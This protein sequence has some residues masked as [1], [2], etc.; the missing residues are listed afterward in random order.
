M[1]NR[2]EKLRGELTA[3]AADLSGYAE[4]DLAPTQTFLELGFDSLFLT[5]LAVQYQ[6]AF[7]QKITFRQLINDVPTIEALAGYLDGVMPADAP[8]AETP[9]E[10]V[11]APAPDTTPAP[12]APA[13]TSAPVAV[14]SVVPV[15]VSAPRAIAPVSEG[16]QGILA[17]QLALMTKQLEML[18]AARGAQSTAASAPVAPAETVVSTAPSSSPPAAESGAAPKDAAP[19]TPS[20]PAGFGPNVSDDDGPVLDAR[21]KAHVARLVARYNARTAG[22]KAAT[23]RDRGVHAD[24]RTAAGFNSLWKEMVYPIVVKKSHG[25]HLWDIDDNQYI[26]LLN[27][28]GP[29]FFGH[30]APFVVEALREQLEDGYEIGPQ[31]PRAGD[32][33]RLMCELTGMDRVSWVNTGSEAVQAAIRIARTVTGRDKIVVFKG[34]YHGNFDEV[35]VRG[36]GPADAPRTMPLAPGIPFKS[37]ENVIALDYGE[38]SAI[39]YIKANADDIAA[40]LVEPVQSRRPEFQPREFLHEL[41]ALTKDEEIVLVF[42]EV[43]T[44]FRIRPGGAQEYFGIE[45]DMATYGKIIGGG[46]PIGVVAGR[47][48]F[49]D[50]FDGGQWSY[51]DASKPMAGVTF[52]AGTFVRH[53]LAI[54]AA[55]ASLQYLISAGPG[56]QEGVNRMT[57]RLATAL[58]DFFKERG[59]KIHVA[60]FASQMFF[61]NEEDSELATLFFYHLRA[62]GVHILEN[63]PSYVTAAHTEEDI[64]AVIDAAKDAVLEMQADGILPPAPTG[65]DTAWR[66]E[67]PLTDS[68][69]ALWFASKIDPLSSCA[70]NESDSI[71]IDGDV[72]EDVFC[73]AVVDTLKNHE[74]FSIRCDEDGVN[75]WVD[76]SA[77]FETERAD[78]RETPARE[79][80][81]VLNAR[82]AEMAKTPFDLEN[83]PLVRTALI[84]LDEEQRVFVI[85]CHHIVFDGYSAEIVVEEIVERYKACLE[86][87]DP[88]LVETQPF[89]L[90]TYTVN[91]APASPGYDDALAYWRG[92]YEDGVPDLLDLPVDRPR[93]GE[94]TVHGATAQRNLDAELLTTITASAKKMGVSLNSFLF[95][96]FGVLMARLS[97][98][99]DFVIAA[100]SAAQADTG[101]HTVGYGVNMLP[102]RTDANLDYSFGDYAKK[103]QTAILDGFVNQEVSFSAIARDIDAPLEENRLAVSEIV[104]NFSRYFSKL[105]MPG[106]K[107]SARENKRVANY[108]D[109][110]VNIRETEKCLS[111]CW[112]YRTALFDA[113][114]INRWIDMWVA[115]MHDAARDPAA[116][117]GDLPLQTAR[118]SVEENFG[119]DLLAPGLFTAEDRLAHDAFER[120]AVRSPD[121]VA[122][123]FE[124]RALTYGEVKMRA[125]RVAAALHAKGAHSGDMVAV[126][127]DR[128]HDVIAAALGVWKAGA[129]YLP[130]DPEFPADRLQYM[131]EDS[132]AAFIITDQPGH[133]LCNRDGVTAISLKDVFADPAP[134][135]AFPTAA[136]AQDD[137][138]YIL[139]TSGSTGNPKGVANSHKALLNFLK[140][141]AVTPGLA[142][143][144]RLLALTT[145]SFDISILEMFLPISIGASVVVASSDEALDG[146]LLSDLIRDHGVSVVQGTPATW[147]LLVEA[148]P[149]ILGNVKALCGGEVMPGAIAAALLQHTA[150]LWNMYGPTETTVWSTCK[151]IIA[152]D[153]ITVGAPIDNTAIYVVDRRGRAAPRGVA[154]E[155]WIGGDGVAIEYLGKPEASAEKF[156]VDPFRDALGA[157]AYKT[158][159]WGRLGDNGDLQIVGRRDDQVKIRGHRIELGEIETALEKHDAVRQAAAAVRKDR[160]GEDLL[161]AYAVFHDAA[162]APS[163]SDVR[164]FLRQSLP[165]YMIPQMCIAMDALPLTNNNKVN[166]KALPDPL[167][168]LETRAAPVAPRSQEER[169]VAAIWSELLQVEA[170]SVTDNFFE[171]GGQS[172]Q[173]AQM[174][175]RVRKEL[176]FRIPPQ[177]V[178]FETLEQLVARREPI[179]EAAE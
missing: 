20:V 113:E 28:F 49:M 75:Q 94:R 73:G 110:F 160:T 166:R 130:L 55:H 47:A 69:R 81:A 9:E 147:R 56:L 91:G 68:Q 42:D 54:A 78:L 176:G 140:S 51:G 84:R 142:P 64:D 156:V 118:P 145:P 129:V 125:D 53:P 37:V 119:R 111:I 134:V 10:A 48:K 58:N 150:S 70:F 59:V 60:H 155:V 95:S 43:I 88:A 93:G 170:I 35:L 11:A 165:H 12:V 126:L 124:G 99:E 105:D 80:G 36:V 17:E 44:G 177:S 27:G 7:K 23:E 169:D 34:D 162:N 40:V 83:G 24:P 117:I 137:V 173:V 90:L 89:S 76:E 102:I 141:M 8:V 164:G 175:A 29:N 151:Q 128:S 72:D 122:T 14:Q 21:Q 92:V 71:V 5:Q 63:F 138:A 61:R 98:Q 45:A 139:Y 87:R 178:V 103:N 26:D 121:A 33:A 179:V 74:A 25:A 52:F 127:H 101:I 163:V 41:R 31:T 152:A 135:A 15:A 132:G 13:P 19:K 79:R 109:C 107:I 104:F 65:V 116:A 131:L 30:R 66:R 146:Y 97:G 136:R 4:S 22:S 1:S 32:A 77:T 159:D 57:T 96:T 153:A 86:G 46:M 16:L 106:C 85:Y 67:F 123:I 6:K 112:D 120:H 149:E 62:R 172:L 167:E 161:I 108:A 143:S 171:L 148:E 157:R 82:L 154:G 3:I 133:A 100:P 174:V 38:A 50:T 39:D 114:T 168:S 18:Q 144:D 2:I 158:G 115:I